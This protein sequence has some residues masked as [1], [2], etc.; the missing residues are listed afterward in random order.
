GQGRR[1]PSHVSKG[2]GAGAA[3]P[4]GASPDANSPAD[5]LCLAS[6]RGTVPGHGVGGCPPALARWH[7]ERQEKGGL[8]STTVGNVSSTAVRPRAPVE[9]SNAIPIEGTPV[10]PDGGRCSAPRCYP[11]TTSMPRI[12]PACAV[13][14]G[15]GQ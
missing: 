3:R 6:A 11:A 9:G 12:C 8:T 7:I 4:G 2:G 13:A 14:A 5:C 1:A 15:R 10:A